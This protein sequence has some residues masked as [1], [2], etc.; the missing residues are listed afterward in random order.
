MD[1]SPDE[2]L[3]LPFGREGG[4][5]SWYLT[6]TQDRDLFTE[7]GPVHGAPT[8]GRTIL[9]FDDDVVA[10]NHLANSDLVA[11]DGAGRLVN[12]LGMEWEQAKKTPTRRRAKR[13]RNL[14]G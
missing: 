7:L 9:L 13:R 8:D 5:K 12:L 3:E 10:L 4:R 14:A 6:L 2:G 1:P 11:M